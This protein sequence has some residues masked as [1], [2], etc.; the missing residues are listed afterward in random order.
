MIQRGLDVLLEQCVSVGQRRP[1]DAF[2]RRNMTW[3]GHGRR[4]LFRLATVQ[5]TRWNRA[6]PVRRRV[7]IVPRMI[8]DRRSLG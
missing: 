1:R 2:P 3:L 6:M 5:Q 7:H 4:R 8:G